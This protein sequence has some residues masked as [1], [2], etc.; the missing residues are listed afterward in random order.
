MLPLWKVCRA[1]PNLVVEGFDP[2][3][4]IDVRREI[5]S[6]ISYAIDNKRVKWID[7]GTY[8]M[9]F[10]Y[11][12]YIYRVSLWSSEEL[13]IKEVTRMGKIETDD[14]G[15]DVFRDWS[16]ETRLKNNPAWGGW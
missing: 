3:T 15:E 11:L 4:P 9:T 16:N 5:A 10:S 2:V 8:R 13:L 1:S 12:G 7:G 6:R 14:D